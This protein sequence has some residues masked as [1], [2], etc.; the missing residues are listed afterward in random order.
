MHDFNHLR[1]QSIAAK[2]RCLSFQSRFVIKVRIAILP[3][4]EP[5]DIRILWKNR[6][7]RCGLVQARRLQGTNYRECKNNRKSGKHHPFP[8]PKDLPVVQYLVLP[9]S[10]RWVYELRIPNRQQ[11]DWRESFK[12]IRIVASWLQWHQS[13]SRDTQR[14]R[15]QCLAESMMAKIEKILTLRSSFPHTSFDAGR[16]R[17]E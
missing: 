12:I 7:L 13:T 8:F 2:N 15:F 9:L 14:A 1:G 17:M 16:F 6:N 5:Q 10:K 3:I 11:V 4:L